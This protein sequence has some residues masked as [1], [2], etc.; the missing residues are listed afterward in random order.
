MK[1]NQQDIHTNILTITPNSSL[2]T[3]HKHQT[4]NKTTTQLNQ[5]ININAYWIRPSGYHR[6]RRR[7]HRPMFISPPPPPILNRKI[8]GPGAFKG[9]D[10]LSLDLLSCMLKNFGN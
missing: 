8:P 6:Q 10:L 5:N 1:V 7:L 2:T 4:L 9:L 3:T